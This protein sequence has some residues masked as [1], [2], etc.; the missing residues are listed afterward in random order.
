M[1]KRKFQNIETVEI[2]NE[3]KYEIDL[4]NDIAWG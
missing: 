3:I 2:Q 1:E 4:N